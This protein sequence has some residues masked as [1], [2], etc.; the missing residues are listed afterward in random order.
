MSKAPTRNA[1]DVCDAGVDGARDHADA[2]EGG[3]ILLA[4]LDRTPHGAV[5]ARRALQSLLVAVGQMFFE[6]AQVAWR[7]RCDRRR[8]D[9]GT[10]ENET[11]F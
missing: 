2:A 8:D 6:S 1:V 11:V 10:R 5:G 9:E 4:E 3:E 7:A